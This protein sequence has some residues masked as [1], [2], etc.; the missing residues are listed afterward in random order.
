M[1]LAE[2]EKAH[3]GITCLRFPPKDAA[4]VWKLLGEL[5]D[6]FGKPL[7]TEEDKLRQASIRASEMIREMAQEPTEEGATP[8]FL[9]SLQGTVTFDWSADSSDRRAFELIN[10]TNQFNLNG[11]RI[12]ESEWHRRLERDDA[13]LAV[14]SYQDKF[15]PLGKIAV[16]L[17]SQQGSVVQVSHW[18]MSCRAFSRRLEHHALDSVFQHCNAEKIEFA[19]EATQKN[20]PLQQFL[21][22]LGVS[23][24]GDGGRSISRSRFEERC[25]IL[26]HQVSNLS[27]VERH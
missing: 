4:G 6:L 21:D 24:N 23:A 11:H 12:E 17:G 19:F 20:Q 16:L 8:D 2:V 5:R 18:V 1:E 15:G 27:R 25:G 13:V 26:P 9:S 22:A 14:A 7:L 3:P 10:K